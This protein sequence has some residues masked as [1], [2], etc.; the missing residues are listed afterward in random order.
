M[1]FGPLDTQRCFRGLLGAMSRPG[2][3]H[4]VQPGLPLVL[5]TLVDHE[6][7]LAEVGDPAWPA[8]DFVLVRGGDSGGELARARQG[9]LLDPA[10]G[11]TAIYEV[12]A[13]GEGPLTVSLS[14]PGIGPDPHTL[15]L[16]GVPVSEVALWRATRSSF[17]LGVDVLLVDRAGRCAALPRSTTLSTVEG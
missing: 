12:E 17:P 4:N 11:A 10:L 16:T 8:A 6:V 7:R 15:H 9:T 1:T 13:V 5:A 3:V 14:G 2:T